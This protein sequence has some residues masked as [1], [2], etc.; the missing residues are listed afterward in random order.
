MLLNYC[1]N[2]CYQY[3]VTDNNHVKH[4][5]NISQDLKKNLIQINV[6]VIQILVLNSN[7]KEHCYYIN[8]TKMKFY[9]DQQLNSINKYLFEIVFY[10]SYL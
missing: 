1:S 3:I 10:V 2:L 7:C 5:I 8:I 6:L 9:F 4:S